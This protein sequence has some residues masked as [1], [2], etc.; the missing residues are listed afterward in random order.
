MTTVEEF[1]RL[2]ESEACFL[3]LRNGEVI[4]VTRPKKRHDVVI[5]RIR[6]RLQPFADEIG[7]FRE[8]FTFR[9][10]AEYELRVADLAFVPWERWDR[11]SDDDNLPGAPDF[12][13]EAA[14]PSNTAEELQ[15]KKQ[16]CL[17]NGCREFWIVYPKLEQ[18]EVS[19][20]DETRT[21]RR[22]S[23]IPLTVFAGHE[24]SVD[25]IFAA[26]AGQR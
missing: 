12:V 23:R 13:V 22:G 9:P 20:R 8:E 24:L 3:E 14:S 21:Y 2:P 25:E 10:L 7:F 18:I 5:Y 19:T 4:Q 17:D 1:R 26:R 6:R 16:I 11:V 15:E